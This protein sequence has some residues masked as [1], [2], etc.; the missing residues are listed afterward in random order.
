MMIGRKSENFTGYFLHINP[1]IK[2]SLT[3]VINH[4]LCLAL[5]VKVL[6][7]ICQVAHNGLTSGVPCLN[8]CTRFLD[9]DA[10][11]RNSVEIKCNLHATNLLLSALGA[12]KLMDVFVK[13]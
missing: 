3:A 9:N 13:A 5:T 12:H 8:I 7:K 4:V 10:F 11:G 2:C 6:R 1:K